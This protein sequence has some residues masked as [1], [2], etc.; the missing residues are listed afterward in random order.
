MMSYRLL[1]LVIFQCIKCSG[2]L[3]PHGRLEDTIQAF[4]EFQMNN[5]MLIFCFI[6]I[7]SFAIFNATGVSVSKFASSAQRSTIDTS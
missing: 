2:K 7:A 3:C 1:G 6:L 5:W 4:Q